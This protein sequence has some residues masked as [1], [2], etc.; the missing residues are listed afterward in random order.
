[1]KDGESPSLPRSDFLPARR[2]SASNPTPDDKSNEKKSSRRR[3][4]AG[5]SRPNHRTGAVSATEAGGVFHHRC[6]EIRL[7][8]ALRCPADGRTRKDV[9]RRG[10]IHEWL[11]GSRDNRDSPRTFRD[12][13]GKISST[14]R[15]PH[16]SRRSHRYHGDSDRCTGRGRIAIS[17]S[18]NAPDRLAG[19]EG[20]ADAGAFSI[21]QRP[22][23]DPAI[24]SSK[25]PIFWYGS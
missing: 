13:V 10:G 25:R 9:S 5:C 8:V 15:H 4:V 18:W 20:S 2:H 6:H 16:Q 22:R 17:F 24:G 23:G 7:P 19:G 1:M 14:Y 12:D 11:S 21:S 3:S